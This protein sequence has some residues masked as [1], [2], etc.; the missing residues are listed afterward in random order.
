MSHVQRDISHAFYFVH[1]CAC[2]NMYESRAHD[3]KESNPG[4]M[5]LELQHYYHYLS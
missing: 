5:I 2:M 4:T 1:E 3:I